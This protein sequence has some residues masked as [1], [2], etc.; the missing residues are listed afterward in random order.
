MTS[1]R[2]IPFNANSF[3]KRVYIENEINFRNLEFSRECKYNGE[4][5]YKNK[6]IKRV[7]NKWKIL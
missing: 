6:T 1:L 3:I 4:F 2:L 7:D 5:I